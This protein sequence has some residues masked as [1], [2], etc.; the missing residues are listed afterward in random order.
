[1]A[2]EHDHRLQ[3]QRDAIDKW[4]TTPANGGHAAFFQLGADLRGTG[5][6]M[7]EIEATLWEEAGHARHPTERRGQIKSIMRTLIQ[8]NGRA[9]A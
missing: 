6:T 5:L 8:G 3:R 4:R 2:K 1:V 9:A 7:A